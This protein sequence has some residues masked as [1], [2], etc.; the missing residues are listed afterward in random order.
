MSCLSMFVQSAG[1]CVL[2]DIA[3]LSCVAWDAFEIPSFVRDGDNGKFCCAAALTWTS[4]LRLCLHTF[5]RLKCVNASSH[6]Q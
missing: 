6:N 1:S 5:R 2:W 4:L 3:E